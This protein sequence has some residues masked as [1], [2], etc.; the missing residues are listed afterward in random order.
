MQGGLDERT[1]S[2]LE[3]EEDTDTE[4]SDSEFWD[5][6]EKWRDEGR[7]SDSEFWDVFEK[8]R[9]GLFG[10][11]AA[12]VSSSDTVPTKRSN[13]AA[14]SQPSTNEKSKKKPKNAESESELDRKLAELLD[15]ANEGKMIP[16]WSS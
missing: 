4:K 9:D 5:V 14:A 12:G 10:R 11:P 3:V 1:R 7:R 8:W 6:F 2:R 15:P 13:P 16:P